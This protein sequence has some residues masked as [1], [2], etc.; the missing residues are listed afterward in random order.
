MDIDAAL[1]TRLIRDQFPV[2]AALPVTPVSPG[3]WDN[4]TFRLGDHMSVRMPSAARYVPQVEKEQHWLPRL[5]PLLPL[6][7]PKPLARGRP[8]EG[9]PWPWSI[10]HWIAGEA[11]D[12]GQIG[13][14]VEFASNLA[15]FLTALQRIPAQAGP[16]PGVHNF[17]R[18][19]SLATYDQETRNAIM[20]LG[21]YIDGSTATAV[22]EEALASRWQR[23]PVSCMS[24]VV[25]D[26]ARLS[27]NLI[28]FPA[29]APQDGQ[30]PGSAQLGHQYPET[31]FSSCRVR[32]YDGKKI[33][34]KNSEAAFQPE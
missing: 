8:A 20:A 6:P 19:G 15:N 1:V 7:I 33:C 4:R 30:V 29:A 17:F 27:P 25:H 21:A 16:P 9:Y 32:M 5:A 18:G 24:G 11:A 26:T 22:W 23:E 14:L 28:C 31:S 3:G 12:V 34:S 10:C 13:D 2:W